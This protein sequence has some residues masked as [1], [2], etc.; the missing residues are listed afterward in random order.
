MASSARIYTLMHDIQYRES[1]SLQNS[2]YNQPTQ[3][4]FFLG[5]GMSTPPTPNIYFANADMV[6]PTASGQFTYETM[7]NVV[8]QFSEP[9]KL[10]TISDTD[11]VLHPTSY[12]GADWLPYTYSY[13]AAS[14]TA[15]YYF[16]GPIPDGNYTATLAAGN[17][18]DLSGNA[19]SA[20]YSFNLYTFGGDA[21]R[22]RIVDIS[23]LAILAMN[24]QGTGKTFSQGDF[25]YDGKVD[26]KDLG[27]LSMNWQKDLPID[28]A[29]AS[30]A[31]IFRAAPRRTARVINLL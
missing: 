23:D 19:M 24:W 25:N 3:T 27:I 18:T 5:A 8:V 1:V 16:W 11:V 12:A 6:P 2:G 28:P 15:T 7:Q 26:A 29:P 22:D 9:M 20:D 10:S 31:S 17:V 14:N 30:P 4:S 13:N 21:N